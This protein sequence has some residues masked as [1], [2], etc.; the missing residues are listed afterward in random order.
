MLTYG[1]VHLKSSEAAV[2]LGAQLLLVERMKW[3]AKLKGW[4]SQPN[5]FATQSSHSRISL[6]SPFCYVQLDL[7]A[8]TMAPTNFEGCLR[9]RDTRT[10]CVF[11]W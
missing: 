5:K 9:L 8:L 4:W 11:K 7:C 10:A 2:A 3:L 1:T 6:L